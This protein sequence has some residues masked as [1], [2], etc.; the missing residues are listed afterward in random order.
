MN[1]KLKFVFVFA[2]MLSLEGLMAQ[3]ITGTVSDQGGVPLP[4]VNV[5][6]KGTTNGTSTDFDGNYTIT[7]SSMDAVLEFSSLGM[8]A[9][10]AAIN[11]RTTLDITME[12]DAQELGEVVV[13]ALGISR[14]KK[15]L[16]YAV[17]EVQ[18]EDVSLVKEPNV[19]NSLAG[20]VAGV[21]VSKTTSGPG[22]G[23]RVVIRGNNS[24]M[25]NNQPLYV[26]DGVPIDNSALAPA[27]AGEYSVTD[28]GSGISDINPDDIESLSVL[29]GPNAAALYGSR[30]SNGVIIITTKRGALKK[31][32]GIS[33]TSSATFED[34]FVLPKY[35]NQYG[36]GTDGNFPTVNPGD[37]LAAQIASVKGNSSWGPRFDGSERLA[38]NGQMRA[39]EAQPNNV[40]DFF[41]TGTS[42]INTLSLSSG[43]ETSSV[44]F[45]YTNSDLQS[46]L[47][48][49]NV[50]RDNFNLR[51]FTKLSDK[52]SLDA[53]V[54]YFLQKANNRPTQGTEGVMA[55]VWPLVRNVQTNDLKKY[56]DLENPFDPNN[57]YGVIAPT[58][59]G[60][61][62]Y[63]ML[64]NDSNSDRR[65]RIS[66]F[67]KLQYD[68]NDWLS[69][70]V[71]V[72]TDAIAQDTELVYSV[73]RHF[74]TAGEVNH[75][76]NKRTET[77]YDFLLMFNKD[78]TDKF[79]LNANVG[80]NGLRFSTIR[81]TTQGKNIKIP[82]RPFLDNTEE[83][84]A[85]Q[86]PLIEKHVNSVYGAFSF[87]YDDML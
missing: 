53:R 11:G 49:S 65:S 10:E 3:T 83:L 85:S 35:Q 19:V 59:S 64:F 24:I 63:W 21:V 30:A 87:A 27:G 4:G 29:K 48:N 46:I 45:S 28:M 2:A 86:S 38:Y 5:I 50:D 62:P 23:T 42:F 66:G 7:V 33:F 60:G 71:R 15:S 52:L 61:N 78:L 34:P 69:A 82:G 74:F 54:T 9:L 79:N 1:Q 18:G 40:E 13:T 36:R 14:E 26:V 32:L 67:A 22:G 12:E 56:Q 51:A 57:P 39:Y 55:Y 8:R 17:T 44:R 20:K 68:F 58:S 81:S 72:G 25:G 31:G 43:N 73:G 76:Q 75:S 84:F 41:E 77:N 80:A 37:P 70:F 47:P 6:E 16:G